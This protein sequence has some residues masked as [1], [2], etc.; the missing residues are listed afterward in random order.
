MCSPCDFLPARRFRTL[1]ERKKYRH[2]PPR[3]VTRNYM[4]PPPRRVAAIPEDLPAAEPRRLLCA[5]ITVFMRLRHAGGARWRSGRRAR[6][7]GLGHLGNPV[8]RARWAS[9]TF[10]HRPRERQ[11]SAWREN[12]ACSSSIRRGRSRRGVA[13][14]G[15]ARVILATAPDSKSI[16]ALV[17][18]L[19]TNGNLVIVWR[20]RR[21]DHR[22]ASPI[23]RWAQGD[24]GLALGNRQRSEDTMQF[25][26]CPESV[27]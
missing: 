12:R 20:R 15:G 18:G 4:V 17:N 2:Q 10:R 25:S 3:A 23:D 16:S 13:E 7:F 22:H 19:S 27:R 5:G 1:P 14:F 24:P 26:A 6:H 21:A 9:R 11:G 8:C